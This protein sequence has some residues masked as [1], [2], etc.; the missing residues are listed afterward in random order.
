MPNSTTGQSAWLNLLIIRIHKTFNDSSLRGTEISKPT[1]TNDKPLTQGSETGCLF[2]AARYSVPMAGHPVTHIP[3]YAVNSVTFFNI[4]CTLILVKL[5]HL[6]LATEKLPLDRSDRVEQIQRHS[7]VSVHS[8]PV[9]ASSYPGT[10]S[11]SILSSL[12]WEVGQT[13]QMSRKTLET[14]EHRW[15]CYWL[16]FSSCTEAR[17]SIFSYIG[18]SAIDQQLS[19]VTGLSPLLSWR[20]R[21]KDAREC[22]EAAGRSRRHATISYL[23]YTCAAAVCARST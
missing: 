7:H 10:S 3:S 5:S 19:H 18:G 9:I 22:K 15:T 1:L 21:P 8:S 2:A 17:K 20:F 23:N 12:D 6:G 11:S 4:V 13:V 16:S 14:M